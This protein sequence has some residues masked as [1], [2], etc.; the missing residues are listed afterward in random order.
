MAIICIDSFGITMPFVWF[1][2]A[3]RIEWGRQTG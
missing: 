2:A 1:G 3:K